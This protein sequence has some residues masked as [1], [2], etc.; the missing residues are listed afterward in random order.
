[1]CV[2]VEK[3][4]KLSERSTKIYQKLY[5][6][7]QVKQ[8]YLCPIILHNY[9]HIIQYGPKSYLLDPI[10][11]LE[12]LYFGYLDIRDPRDSPMSRTREEDGRIAVVSS[13]FSQYNS[14]LTNIVIN[15]PDWKSL[16]SVQVMCTRYSLSSCQQVFVYV[17]A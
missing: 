11:S 17:L 14:R 6:L 1:M 12:L 10:V 5:S 16:L 13:V 3:W 9:I 8:Q 4:R 2:I 15:M 7:N